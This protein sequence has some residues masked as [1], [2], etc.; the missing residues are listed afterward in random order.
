MTL[1]QESPREAPRES[2]SFA[3]CRIVVIETDAR[4]LH[5]L[6]LLLEAWGCSVTAAASADAALDHVVAAGT[7]PDLVIADYRL[8]ETTTGIVAI[9]QIAKA[10]DAPV[11]GLIITGD[12]DPRR[13]R[14]AAPSGYPLLCKPVA[15]DALRKAVAGVLGS[16]PLCIPGRLG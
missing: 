13:R 12:T 5:G 14:E 9:R 4:V 3:P 16:G 6:R 2:W 10:T 15:A 8:Q 11:K 7:I 1:P